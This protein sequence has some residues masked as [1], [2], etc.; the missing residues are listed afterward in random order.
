VGASCDVPVQ[1]CL[2]LTMVGLLF[3]ASTVMRAP[4]DFFVMMMYLTCC[5]R[6]FRFLSSSFFM[7]W[8]RLVV[9]VAAVLLHGD[10]VDGN[11]IQRW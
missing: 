9:V 5:L 11:R 3:V 4:C 8:L 1:K 7:A 2:C 10:D 6:S